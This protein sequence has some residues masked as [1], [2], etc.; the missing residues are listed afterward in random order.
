[1]DALLQTE[2]P[3]EKRTPI[4]REHQSRHDYA[5]G[6]LH[7]LAFEHPALL[8]FLSPEWRAAKVSKS[9]SHLA[10]A[11][12][13]LGEDHPT[14][15]MFLACF[16]ELARRGYIEL[17]SSMS[18]WDHAD[19]EGI[20]VTKKAPQIPASGVVAEL[21][22]CISHA[23]A[24]VQEIIRRFQE[25]CYRDLWAMHTSIGEAEAKAYGYLLRQTW[26]KAG[27][28]GWLARLGVGEDTQTVW[29][30]NGL[31]ARAARQ[32]ISIL[33]RHIDEFQREA[34]KKYEKLCRNI[35]EGMI[36]QGKPRPNPLFRLP[37][38]RRHPAH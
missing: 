2:K 26:P 18:A 9:R 1:M 5:E 7:K 33:R 36:S 21:F 13:D 28:S 12:G 8:L 16:V 23:H 37:H 31:K 17:K 27:F 25:R 14:V 29:V 15:T 22:N 3:K 4:A 30:R 24:P 6:T 19:G 34:P 20:W 35:M 11:I 32:A 38:L 10:D